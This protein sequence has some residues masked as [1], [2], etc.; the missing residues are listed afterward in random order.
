MNPDAVPWT[1]DRL[2]LAEAVDALNVA[3]WQRGSAK[4]SD[5]PK[6]IPRP[7]VEPESQTFGKGAI[8]YDEM[9]AWLGWS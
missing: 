5:F 2:L 8:P 7:G 6:P 3:N 1:L 9:A 4:R